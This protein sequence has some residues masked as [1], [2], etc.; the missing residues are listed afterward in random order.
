MT[1]DSN[2]LTR[3]GDPYGSIKP[4]YY[5]SPDAIDSDLFEDGYEQL[6]DQLDRD[7][8][9]LSKADR[10][11]V[12]ENYDLD[13]S[14]TTQRNIRTRVRNRVLSAYFDTQYLRYLSDRDRRLI[15]ENAR[16][17][18]K[19]LNFLHGFKEFVRFTYFGLLE[20]DLDIDAVEVLEK[21]IQEAEQKHATKLGKKVN[22]EVD[23]E[24]TH[25]AGDSIEELERRYTR[26]GRLE[27]DELEVLVNSD[28]TN[29]Q[30]NITDANDI[31][32]VDALYYD[33]RQ[34]TKAVS[35]T[36]KDVF[37]KRDTDRNEAISIVD[38]LDSMFNE[39]DVY[40]YRDLGN[41]LGWLAQFDEDLS[42]ELISKINRLSQVAE[43]FP[44]Q[45]S[46]STGLSEKD[47]NLVKRILRDTDGNDVE[48]ALNKQTR[49]P[50]ANK[51]WSPT[52]DENVQRF[53][54]RVEVARE[55]NPL[56]SISDGINVKEKWEKVLHSAEFDHEHWSEYMH[57][58]RVSRF[59]NS[60]KDEMESND[61]LSIDDLLKAESHEEQKRLLRESA[62]TFGSTATIDYP[63]EVYSEALEE[64]VSDRGSDS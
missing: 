4:W 5:S 42:E 24:I 59:K 51:S 44:A 1:G 31:D 12:L 40:S 54:A 20:D 38:W 14:D 45:M 2:E 34:P 25:V 62:D 33:A 28:H 11:F 43:Y 7:R 46:S 58:Q 17:S 49:P 60:I 36:D 39:Y 29:N 35:K 64:L 48:E 53:I 18:G 6:Y 55:A 50:T 56:F 21:A 16:E 52:E 27:R 23:I 9:F 13:L 22:V 37:K 26:H 57:D 15:F 61:E 10:Q 30:S 8:G 41:I 47:M 63:S 19:N 3:G 32:L